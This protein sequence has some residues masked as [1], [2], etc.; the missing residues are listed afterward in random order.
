MFG[1]TESEKTL[2]QMD[3]P[4]APGGTAAIGAAAAGS[5]DSTPKD[6]RQQERDCST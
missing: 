6:R 1:G 3:L 5:V 2:L 4:E